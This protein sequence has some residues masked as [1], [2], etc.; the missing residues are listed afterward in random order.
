MNAR[1]SFEQEEKMKCGCILFTRWW[2][3]IC[4]GLSS[5]VS[6]SLHFARFLAFPSVSLNSTTPLF[7]K[8]YKSLLLCL[9]IIYRDA[10]SRFFCLFSLFFKNEFSCS[11]DC[12]PTLYVAK[13]GL[14]QL[15]LSLPPPQVLEL[16]SF[17]WLVYSSSK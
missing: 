17:A 8:T 16:K 11:P 6:V 5:P 14:E 12:P 4:L 2:L 3:G 13:D 9:R 7:F 10:Y 15:I 1:T